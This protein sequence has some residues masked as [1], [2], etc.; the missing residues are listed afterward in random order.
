MNSKRRG[1]SLCGLPLICAQ[2]SMCSLSWCSFVTYLSATRQTSHPT[3]YAFW[4]HFCSSRMVGYE[5]LLRIFVQI[6]FFKTFSS[7]IF[8]QIFFF[9]IFSPKVFSLE[10]F[11]RKFFSEFFF[12][13]FSPTKCWKFFSNFFFW[14]LIC[15][16]KNHIFHSVLHLHLVSSVPFLTPIGS[17]WT[18]IA[19]RNSTNYQHKPI[20]VKIQISP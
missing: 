19:R 15:L 7:E 12:R 4:K 17:G 18:N 8:L 16:I 9:R 13:N 11:L 20:I 6:F 5:I 1:R 2:L 14:I 3:T 10:I